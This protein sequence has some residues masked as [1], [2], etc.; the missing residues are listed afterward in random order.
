MTHEIAGLL[1]SKHRPTGNSP[2]VKVL[3]LLLQISECGKFFFFLFLNDSSECSH[4]EHSFMS[5]L[6]S[7][8]QE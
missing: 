6:C 3:P 7:L 5:S 8:S 4:I 2:L 1:L